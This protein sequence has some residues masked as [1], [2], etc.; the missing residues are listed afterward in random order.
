MRLLDLSA[1]ELTALSILAG[2]A[3]A[4]GL[5]VNQQNT[6]GN[7]LMSIGQT[8]ES[9]AA[10]QTL[11]NG[12]APSPEDAALADLKRRLEQLEARLGSD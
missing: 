6:L 11:L 2:F 4:R 9:I 7:F 10:Q 5:D 8:L 1:G 12:N 3:L